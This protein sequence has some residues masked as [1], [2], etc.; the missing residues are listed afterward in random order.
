MGSCQR[1]AWLWWSLQVASADARR[2]S[3]DEMCVGCFTCVYTCVCACA[4]CTPCRVAPQLTGDNM[5]ACTRR[6]SVFLLCKPSLHLWVIENSPI[7]AWAHVTHLLIPSTQLQEFP[8][9]LWESHPSAFTPPNPPASIIP[10]K[11][12]VT[13]E[14]KSEKQ[15]N[16]TTDREEKKKNYNGGKCRG[17]QGV[18]QETIVKILQRSERWLKKCIYKKGRKMKKKKKESAMKV[19]MW[20]L[21]R[22]VGA[23]FACS[24]EWVSWALYFWSLTAI[25]IREPEVP[26]KEPPTLT[27]CWRSP[28]R[29]HWANPIPDNSG[30]QYTHAP[31]TRARTPVWISAQM[32]RC[33]ASN[34]CTGSSVVYCLLCL[35]STT[36]A[37]FSTS[38]RPPRSTLKQSNALSDSPITLTRKFVTMETNKNNKSKRLWTNWALQDNIK[39]RLFPNDYAVQVH[40]DETE[41]LL[42]TYW[43]MHVLMCQPAA[44]CNV[45]RIANV[46]W[47][48][49]RP[50]MFLFWSGDSII[51]AKV[52]PPEDWLLTGW[53][54]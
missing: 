7:R 6:V 9:Y 25:W 51:T 4:V 45:I 37:S 32:I 49:G 28:A 47:E 53:W 11:C 10:G 1:G 46:K 15:K 39:Q 23:G 30:R 18:R 26:W 48:R 40:S 38:L 27:S 21:W 52:K 50:D 8:T 19:S 54:D 17:K 35:L 3:G 34:L 5:K 41:E 16:K 22:I 20:S 33:R 24:G 2:S 44:W 36:A 31:C 29:G 14:I 13:I 42:S 12:T 43:S